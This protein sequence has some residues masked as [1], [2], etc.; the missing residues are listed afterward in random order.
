MTMSVYSVALALHIASG[1]TALFTGLVAM[2]ALKG[3]KIHRRAGL[4]FFY[5]MLLVS[6]SALTIA[7]PKG[8]L[9]LIFIA[10]FALYQNISG[11]RAIHNKSRIPHWTDWLI[12]AVGGLNGIG[13]LLTGNIVL[14]VFGGISTFLAVGD[15]ILYAKVLQGKVIGKKEWLR[16]H[17]GM[18][19]GTYIATSTAF[20]VVN[21][22]QFDP[23]WVPWLL[24]TAIGVPY[25]AYMSRK[26]APRKPRIQAS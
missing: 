14:L 22:Q 4:V 25:L 8:N 5:A 9:F 19:M 20:L 15:T 26:H 17:I 3:G 11:Y 1:F 7:I 16:Q 21:I 23:Y 13:M 6:A 24:P 2:T 10:I 12:T 18:M